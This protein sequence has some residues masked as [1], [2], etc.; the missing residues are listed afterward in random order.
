MLAEVCCRLAGRL[1]GAHGQVLVATGNFIGGQ[2]DGM[3]ALV[4]L[5][6][7]AVQA[8]GHL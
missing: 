2:G 1:L 7:H 5:A 6:D 8:A 3:D 4:Y